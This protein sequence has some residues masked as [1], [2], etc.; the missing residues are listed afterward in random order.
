MH[1]KFITRLADDEVFVFGSNLNG[2]HGA[3]AAGYA[4][5]NTT[6]NTWRTDQAFLD[7]KSRKNPDPRGKWA[8]YGIGEGFQ[9]GHEGCSYAIPTVE[10]P[11]LQGKVN[12]RSFT[13]SLLGLVNYAKLHPELTFLVVQLGATRAEGGYSWLGRDQVR[14]IW[15]RIH[16]YIGVPVNIHLLESQNIQR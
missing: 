12:I 14:Q 9:R 11:G 1:N 10:R 5:R 6:A 13:K 7:I 15:Q 3:G 4:M 16:Y 2:F 8:V